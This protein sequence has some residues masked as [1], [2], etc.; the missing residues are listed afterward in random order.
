MN[1]G[2][3]DLY[4]K[5]VSEK[6]SQPENEPLNEARLRIQDRQTFHL[7]E[8]T[9]AKIRQRETR[10]FS[11]SPQSEGRLRTDKAYASIPVNKDS[12]LF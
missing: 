8:T 6:I 1:S 3:A 2:V 5:C 12:K 4:L 9:E 7:K 10:D 11:S